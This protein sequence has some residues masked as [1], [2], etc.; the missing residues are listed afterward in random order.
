MK[1]IAKLW[2]VPTSEAETLYP[3]NKPMIQVIFVIDCDKLFYLISWLFQYLIVGNELQDLQTDL[4][5]GRVYLQC[6][7]RVV[8]G[9]HFVIFLNFLL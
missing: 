9:R 1:D 2:A 8:S 4:R 3:H 6:T 7:H 5:V